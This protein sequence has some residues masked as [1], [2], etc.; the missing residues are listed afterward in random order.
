MFLVLSVA[1]LL[2]FGMVMLYSSLLYGGDLSFLIKQMIWS[3][4][5]LCL[6]FAVA[7]IDYRLLKD[8]AWIGLLVSIGILTLVLH[9]EIGKKI[10]GAR[11]WFLIGEYSFQP[12]EVAKLGMIIFVAWYGDRYRRAMPTFW[13]GLAL[14]GIGIAAILIL[15]FV[16]P[17]RG[18]TLLLAAV[19]VVMLLAAGVQWKHLLP[20]LGIG[21][22]L[23]AF[24]LSND[25]IRSDRIRA[26]INPEA[27]KNGA[28]YQVWLSVLALGSGGIEGLGLGNSRQKLGFLPL[29]E[30]DFIFSIIG[31]ELGLLAGSAVILAFAILV[32]S[33]IY[34]SIKARDHF[35]FLLGG[36]V[37]FLIGLQAFV[38][39]GVA[40][41][42]LPNKG[43]P[44]PFI[45]YG[46]SSL[47]VMLIGIGLLMSI[48]RGVQETSKDEIPNS[49]PVLHEPDALSI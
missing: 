7:W 49:K 19:S 3:A 27:M 20:L 1:G 16:E 34:I 29:K 48:A 46:G 6:C 44:L 9:P 5:G 36:G 24:S 23:L 33:G 10:N 22:A 37:T 42:T 8:W 26:W 28:G 31:E 41:N 32:I 17:D 13:R 4:L 18:T 45:S 38:N 2:T 12:S 47:L 39:I 43:L 15:I 14:P 30:S 11:R 40:T 25:P 21:L 35:G